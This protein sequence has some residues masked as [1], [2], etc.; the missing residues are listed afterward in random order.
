MSE[1]LFVI[2]ICFILFWKRRKQLG[3]TSYGGAK[4]LLIEI[5]GKELRCSHCNHNIF[6][7]REG[8]LTTTWLTLVHLN[9]FNRSA[10]CFVCKNCGFV[11]WFLSTDEKVDIPPYSV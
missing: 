3:E 9:S 6:R 2:I 4:G 1:L 11:H 10:R 8:L 7:K 5:K